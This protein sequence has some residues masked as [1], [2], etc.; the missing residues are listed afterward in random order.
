M[1]ITPSNQNIIALIKK[2]TILSML[3]R[4]V[5][6]DGRKFNEYRHL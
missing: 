2:D 5:R 3:E 6:I 1:S 4:G